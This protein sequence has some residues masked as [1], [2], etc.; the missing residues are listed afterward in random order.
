MIMNQQRINFIQEQI[1]NQH[2]IKKNQENDAEP[3]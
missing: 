1:M 3:A 2:K